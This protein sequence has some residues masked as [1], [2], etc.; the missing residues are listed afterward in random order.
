MNAE[1]LSS[2][3]KEGRDAMRAALRELIDA[4]YILSRRDRVPN[5]DERWRTIRVS[6]EARGFSALSLVRFL[7]SPTLSLLYY[8]LKPAFRNEK[9]LMFYLLTRHHT[10]GSERLNGVV[11]N[12]LLR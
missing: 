7:A 8:K 3:G 2:I 9:M 10:L 6:S 1:E 11:Q 4:G 12:M 5:T